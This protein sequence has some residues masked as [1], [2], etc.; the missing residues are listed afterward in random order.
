LEVLEPS[1]IFE[2]KDGPYMPLDKED[3]LE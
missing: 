3:I 2:V 1:A